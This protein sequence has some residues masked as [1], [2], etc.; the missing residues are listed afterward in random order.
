MLMFLGYPDTSM[1]IVNL[2]STRNAQGRLKEA[3]E[4]GGPAVEIFKKGLGADQYSTMAA[5]TKQVSWYMDQGRL[6]DAEKLGIQVTET[7]KV[8]V[9]ANDPSTLGSMYILA[10]IYWKQG[11][12]EEAEKAYTMIQTR[13][14]EAGA[15]DIILVHCKA[16]LFVIYTSQGRW[17]QAEKLGVEVMEGYGM[18]FGDVHHWTLS[19]MD[20]LA[21]IRMKLGRH[22]DAIRL[23]QSCVDR[24][25][26][27]FGQEEDA[28][29]VL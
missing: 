8:T 26:R 10:T 23:M 19:A 24:G 13:E 28:G 1:S 4:L 22:D 2:S 21:S 20:G 6:A 11:R 9:G 25:T 15:D 16:A 7:L 29:V 3:E 5:M 27:A 14:S 12:L 17:E 18:R